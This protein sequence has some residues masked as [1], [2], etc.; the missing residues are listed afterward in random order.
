MDTGFI[1]NNN[2]QSQQPAESTPAEPAI[3]FHPNIPHKYT[4]T[5]L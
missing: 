4:A 2:Q 1:K 5:H 3:I